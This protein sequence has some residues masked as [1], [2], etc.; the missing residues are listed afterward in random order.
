[1]IELLQASPALWMTTVGVFSLLVG[2]FLNVVIHRLPL[3][4]QAG[5]R[6]ECRLLLEL[7]EQ[8]APAISLLR[9]RSQC[10]GCSQPI[11]WYDNIPVLSYLM[12][13][14]RCRRCGQRISPRYPVVE[15]LTALLSVVVA[16]QLGF[17]L[18][19]M[20]AIVLTWALVA[21]SGIDLDH[22][23]LPDS[24]TLPA[25]WAGLLLS[26][27]DGGVTPTEAIIGA[28]AGYLSLWLVF[29]GFRLLT[30]KEGMGHGDFKLLA[31][32]GAWLG[33]ESLP[34]I[35]LLSSVVGAVM[36]GLLMASGALR[37][38]QPMPFGPFIAAAGW[39]ALLWGD[40]IWHA[41]L[42]FSG[43]QAG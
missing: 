33:W 39:I 11:A 4:M 17:G 24:I 32:F 43:L 41:Y 12:L 20:S 3:M 35:I 1:M 31:V 34:L 13:Q 27:A 42:A 5:W 15:L 23:L 38:D 18:A 26:L 14:G 22:Q 30:G 8:N 2:S 9:P 28:A 19:G 40:A 10:P 36:G 6:Q 25:L 7:P 29:H 21:L 16:W 37:R